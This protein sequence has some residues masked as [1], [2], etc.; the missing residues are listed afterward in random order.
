MYGPNKKS[1]MQ[2]SRWKK[3]AVVA[4]ARYRQQSKPGHADVG[5]QRVGKRLEATRRRE[6]VRMRVR[7][8]AKVGAG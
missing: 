8:Q 1:A 4:H 5:Q 2:P 6:E 3:V 7:E